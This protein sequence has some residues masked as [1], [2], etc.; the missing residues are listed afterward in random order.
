MRRMLLKCICCQTYL[1][2][3]FFSIQQSFRAVLVCNRIIHKSNQLRLSSTLSLEN[4]NC[5]SFG[6]NLLDVSRIGRSFLLENLNTRATDYAKP[7]RYLTKMNKNYDQTKSINS[8]SL[9]HSISETMIS[10]NSN[11]PAL[12]LKTMVLVGIR[13]Q[14]FQC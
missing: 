7:K 13:L 8:F 10:R 3:I 9:F 14:Q 2:R 12:K 6:K 5:V 1:I 4:I 11:D